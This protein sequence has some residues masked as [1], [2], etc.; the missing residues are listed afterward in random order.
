M[1][2]TGS[3]RHCWVLLL[4]EVMRK[5]YFNMYALEDGAP[6]EYHLKIA[7]IQRHESIHVRR[8]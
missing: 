7:L 1:D 2:Y 4:S 6:E 3:G 8:L 5:L